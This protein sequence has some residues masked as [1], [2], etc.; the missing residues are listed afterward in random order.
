MVHA[1]EIPS[2]PDLRPMKNAFA[3]W[4]CQLDRRQSANGPKKVAGSHQYWMNGDFFDRG[5]NWILIGNAND[6]TLPAQTPSLY[7]TEL[8]VQYQPGAKGLLTLCTLFCGQDLNFLPRSL[9]ECSQVR[10]RQISA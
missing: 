8:S 4:L 1:S 6:K 5:D 7:I 9:R 10:P 2:T 3:L